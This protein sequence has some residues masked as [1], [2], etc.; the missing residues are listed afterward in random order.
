MRTEALG[1]SLNK[2]LRLK[3]SVTT[4]GIVDHLFSSFTP[5][6]NPCSPKSHLRLCDDAVCARVCALWTVMSRKEAA[7]R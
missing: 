3:V 7:V 5:L 2:I 1:Q 4:V 6:D